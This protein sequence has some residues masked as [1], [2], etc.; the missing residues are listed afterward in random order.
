MN[1]SSRG[2]EL[3]HLRYFVAVFEELHFG[4]AA[5]RLNIAQPPLSQAIRKL[6]RDL[7]VELFERTSRAVSPTAAGRALADE[8][9][10]V[11]ARFEFAVAETQ[12]AGGAESPLR[13]GCTTYV[14]T[15]LLRRFLAALNEREKGVRAQVTHLI[16][17]E[18]V[19]LL[20]AGE[21]DLG[22]LS[23][24]EDY[25]KLDWE[26]LFAGETVCVLLPKHH[27]LAAKPVVTPEDLS[28]EAFLTFP[29][30]ANPSY[31]DRMLLMLERAGYR[32]RKL[33]ATS[34]D[35]RDVMLAVADGIGVA[36][37]P[38]SL[39]GLNEN[40]VVTRALDRVLPSPDTIVAWRANAPRRLQTRLA[41]VREIARE[42]HEAT[43][44]R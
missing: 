37:V 13:I 23:H 5:E 29:R 15:R 4:R 35:P 2:I 22:I 27:R 32:F 38:E 10:E 41:A 19:R 30:E 25:E 28:K 44:T 26:P 24:T 9:R 17:S 43:A 36:F 8:A 39:E 33:Y 3:R 11:L 42:L 14:P 16:N 21:L 7:G 12:R 40:G 18:Q 34:T 6:E 31:Y 20:R 1:A